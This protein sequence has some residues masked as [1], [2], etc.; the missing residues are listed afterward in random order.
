MRSVV[1]RKNEKGAVVVEY[2]MGL[3]LIVMAALVGA[4][5][6][7]KSI[8]SNYKTSTD[9]RPFDHEEKPLL[10]KPS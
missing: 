7:T 4:V 8:Q 5:F 1:S 10:V 6:L 2:A 9:S 3:S